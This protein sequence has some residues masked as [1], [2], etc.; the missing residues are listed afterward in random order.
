M[1]AIVT[2]QLNDPTEPPK[3]DTATP[4]RVIDPPAPIVVVI[5]APGVNPVPDTVT[6]IPLGP[7]FGVSPIAGLVTANS[8]AAWSLPPS[9]PVAVI[10]YVPA[11][12]LTV[13]VQPLYVPVPDA[14]HALTDPIDPPRLIEI[15]IVTPGVNPAPDAVTATPLGP[16]VGLGVSDR[17]VT[18]NAAVA[19]SKLPSDPV[20]VTG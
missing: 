3:E 10:V 12:P 11:A 14:V 16:C 20:A 15:V 9:A 4:Q 2:T 5:V 7:W 17:V 18:V 6:E 19:W 13:N 1:S 8:T